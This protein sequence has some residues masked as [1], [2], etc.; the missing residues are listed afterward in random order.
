MRLYSSVVEKK[1][2]FSVNS[3]E[4]H[5]CDDLDKHLQVNTSSRM[6]LFPLHFHNTWIIYMKLA[7]GHGPSGFRVD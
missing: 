5:I 6:R 7:M 4:M 2:I 1:E 3:M